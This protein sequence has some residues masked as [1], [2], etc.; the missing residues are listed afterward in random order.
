MN[1]RGT[2]KGE[3]GGGEGEEGS[4]YCQPGSR[5]DGHSHHSTR[6][7]FPRSKKGLTGVQADDGKKGGLVIKRELLRGREHVPQ[8]IYCANKRLC[9]GYK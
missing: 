1:L 2:V 5:K 3:R 4:V 8:C 6:K 7:G 9:L